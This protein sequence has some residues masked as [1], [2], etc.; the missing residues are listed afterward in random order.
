[1][2]KKSGCCKYGRIGGQAL[3][4]G[5]LMISPERRAMAVRNPQ[6]EIVVEYL[7]PKKKIRGENIPLVRGSIR[8]VQ[9]LLVGLKAMTRSA[10]LAF[11]EEEE[12]KS[13]WAEVMTL[14]FSFAIAVLIFILLPNLVVTGFARYLLHVDPTLG[15]NAVILNLIEG[16]FRI[17]IFLAYIYFATKLSDIK[18]VWMYH[19]AEHMTIA[20]N[21]DDRE[22]TVEN[23]R[24][25]SRLHPRCG[26]AF[27]VIVMIIG[28]LIVALTGWN[29]WYINLLWRLALLP[30]VAGVAYEVITLAGRYDN[31]M[32]RL[33]SK[34]GLWLQLLTTAEPEDEMIEVAIAALKAVRGDNYVIEG[35]Y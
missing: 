3:I 24:R 18:R 30:V 13:N 9:Q 2:C 21:E 5:V 27:L 17:G 22:L 20:C 23:V 35:S 11:D 32:T 7:P 6:K 12:E 4:E 1:M 19:G 14:L 15:G 16:L 33:I 31:F 8:L 29:T 34:P 28:I 26:T 25:Y 10:D